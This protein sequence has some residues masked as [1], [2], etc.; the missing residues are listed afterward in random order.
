MNSMVIPWDA[1]G[2]QDLENSYYYSEE[3]CDNAAE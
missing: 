1:I 2:M 3:I